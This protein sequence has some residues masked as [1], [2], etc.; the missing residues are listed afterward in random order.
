MK[1]KSSSCEF[2]N[3]K[4]EIWTQII[5]KTLREEMDLKASLTYGLTL[6]QSDRHSKLLEEDHKTSRQT[7]FIGGKKIQ[8]RQRGY[9]AQ[10]TKTRYNVQV[11]PSTQKCRNCGG[12]YPHIGGK[13]SCPAAGKKCFECGK[14]GHFGKYCMSKQRQPTGSSR[15]HSHQQ[16]D[17]HRY[18]NGEQKRHDRRDNQEQQPSDTDEE[19][20]YTIMPS[21]K[22]PETT[23]KVAEVPVQ[24]IIDTGSSVNILNSKIL[25]LSCS[26]PKQRYSLME[27]ETPCISSVNLRQKSNTI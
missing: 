14:I 2:T 17:R 10:D 16:Q 20:I 4:A 1:E 5:H 15:Q 6:E 22:T 21:K 23:V 13:S 19:F 9:T 3:A 24:V 18:Q 25:V 12:S 26:Q 8:E 7:N 11:K 27:H